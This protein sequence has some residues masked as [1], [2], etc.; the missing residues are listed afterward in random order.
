MD[1]PWRIQMFGGLRAECG[2]RDVAHFRT[3]KT[4]SLLA[5]LAFHLDRSHPRE[6]L[7]EILWPECAPAAGRQ[8]LSM[9]LSSLRHQLEPPGVPAGSVIQADR[10]A[11]QLN[12]S[13]VKTDVAG[14]EEALQRAAVADSGRQG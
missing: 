4:G 10:F 2:E 9:A 14:F 7:T 6:I 12:P 1:A 3:Q 8:S 11:V 5:Y 13:V